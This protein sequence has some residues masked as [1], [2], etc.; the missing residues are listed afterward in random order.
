MILHS[1]PDL[2]RLGKDNQAHGGLAH[3]SGNDPENTPENR[4]ACHFREA[5]WSGVPKGPSVSWRIF[6]Q[7]CDSFHK[8]E[9]LHLRAPVP[10][11]AQ[12]VL[13]G[14][15]RGTAHEAR[16]RAQPGL[17]GATAHTRGRPASQE[18]PPRP[19][20]RAG[21]P[22]NHDSGAGPPSR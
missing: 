18:P 4:P 9:P 8:L 7:A 21:F 22:A 2:S 10:G 1:W 17:Q 12:G 6:K 14:I 11:C 13:Q 16:R 5:V 3:G 19:S 15:P 20:C